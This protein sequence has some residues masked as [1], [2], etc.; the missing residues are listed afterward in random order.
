[1]SKLKVLFVFIGA[2]SISLAPA[3]TFQKMTIEEMFELADANSRSIRMFRLAEEEAGQA[4]KVARNAQLPSIDVS[5]S[6][7]YSVTWVT[8]I[9]GTVISKTGKTFLCRTSAITLQ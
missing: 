5:V 9:C 7:S 6:A 4:V 8:D 3:Q 1:M 2:L